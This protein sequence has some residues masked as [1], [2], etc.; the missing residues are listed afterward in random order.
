MREGTPSGFSTMSIG[1]PS[2]MCGMS[3][4]GTILEI[5]PLLPWR[6]AILS[7]G[8]SRRFTARYTFTIFCTP[9]GSSSPLGELL[10]LRLEGEIELDA[11][12]VQA[13][14][15]LLELPGGLFAR[16]P[17][18]EPAVALDFHQ[19]RLG[20][21][22]ALRELLRP[23]VGDLADQ[24]AL[25][26][27]EGVVLD[28]AQLVV[29]VLLVALQLVVD[30]LLGALVALDALAREHLHVDH[31]AR[32]ARGH[33]Q[34]RVL[35]VRGLLAEDRAQQLLLRREL[36]LALGRDLAHQH[37][38]RLDLRADVDDAR[39]V[40][41][42]ELRFGQVGDVARDFLRLRAWCR[43]PPPTAPRC[44]SR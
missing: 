9:G 25:D 35:H 34:R 29:Q 2:A 3:S 31:R 42:R 23:A 1:V 16:Q 6:P 4:T 40:Q 44:G 41:P 24:Q 12:L 36:G 38:T 26:A 11:L 14:L 18:V 32:H 39:L 19:I 13:R 28:D 17:D 37:V 27:P 8:C 7:P 10:L 5:T 43:A 30:D 21:L 33:A 22:G 15:E 20:D